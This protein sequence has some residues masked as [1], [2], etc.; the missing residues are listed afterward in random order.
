[1]SAA[2]LKEFIKETL[3]LL[4]EK[5]RHAK[6]GG[7]RTDIGA[8]RQL[9]PEKFR[10]RVR[11]AV[12]GHGGDAAKAAS[13]LGVAKRTLYYYLD[14]EKSLHTV[15]TSDERAE[16]KEKKD[17]EKAERLRKSQAKKP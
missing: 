2:L 13:E 14:D 15:K 5:K 16:E 9:N 7:P 12:N 3:D 11:A 6:P 17:K 1:M 8:V 4:D 10:N